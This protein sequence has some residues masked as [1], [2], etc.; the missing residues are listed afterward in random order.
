MFRAKQAA[1]LAPGEMPV[2]ALFGGY[3]D[4]VFVVGFFILPRL[5]AALLFARA[6]R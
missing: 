4:V 5:A 6:A 1:A 3:S 2:Y